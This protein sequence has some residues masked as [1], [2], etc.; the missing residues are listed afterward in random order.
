MKIFFVVVVVISGSGLFWWGRT[1]W[2]R[3]QIEGAHLDQGELFARL[4]T[5]MNRK[6]DEEQEFYARR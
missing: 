4:T 3:S 2:A 5:I 1:R 6:H